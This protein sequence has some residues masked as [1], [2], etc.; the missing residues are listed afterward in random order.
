MTTQKLMRHCANMS[1]PAT[2]HPVL[3]ILTPHCATS[4]LVP[5]SASM[6]FS[7]TWI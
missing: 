6:P 5:V 2:D 4:M 1:H 7:N 3:L